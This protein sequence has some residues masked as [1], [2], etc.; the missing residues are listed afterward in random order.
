[1]LLVAVA[2][3]SLLVGSRS[4]ELRLLLLLLLVV[5]STDSESSAE[6]TTTEVLL[7]LL[8]SP[9]NSMPKRRMAGFSLRRG[10]GRMKGSWEN[11]STFMKSWV[12]LSEVV[13]DV[14]LSMRGNNGREGCVNCDVRVCI[15]RKQGG[16]KKCVY[17]GV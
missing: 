5:V 2:V 3:S 6:A 8:F 1:M 4:N 11:E 7:L 12:S 10:A 17:E 9:A 14:V 16:V 13:V 15:W